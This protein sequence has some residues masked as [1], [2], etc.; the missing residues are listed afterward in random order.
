MPVCGS[1]HA[2]MSCWDRRRHFPVCLWLETGDTCSIAPKFT[3]FL[4]KTACLHSHIVS[5]PKNARHSSPTR[6]VTLN[7]HLKLL[8]T[9]C[10]SLHDRLLH[11]SKL[12]LTF[13]SA[14]IINSCL[15]FL[16]FLCLT[17]STVSSLL[18]KATITENQLANHFGSF[19]NVFRIHFSVTVFSD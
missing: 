19:E 18:D 9:W 5:K 11:C 16:F 6:T 3:P 8:K 15:S 2:V 4:W 17:L 10:C 7:L 13:M 1:C 14:D 12:Q